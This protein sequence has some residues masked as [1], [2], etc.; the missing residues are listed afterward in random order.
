[1]SEFLSTPEWKAE[2]PRVE[3]A[4][5]MARLQAQSWLDTRQVEGAEERNAEI[6]L[7]A[8]AMIQPERIA[9]R[10][11]F[12]ERA[13]NNPKGLYKIVRAEND[14]PIG[15][16]FGS[17]RSEDQELV[18]LYVDKEH[19]GTGVAQALMKDFIE[20]AD[21]DRPIQVGVLEDNERAQ[22]FYEKSGFEIVP[23][24]LRP[25][26]E[27]KYLFEITMQRK[28]QNEIQS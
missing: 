11:Q 20:W 24:T 6:Q 18:S 14:Q 21:P 10:Q 25:F 16:L 7:Y 17:K 26:Q 19:H 2:T 22:R 13:L 9:L 3:D 27:S 4:E 23:E 28:A 8:N 1:M 15:L 12:I 5:A